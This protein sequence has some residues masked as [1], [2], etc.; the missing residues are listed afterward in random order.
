MHFDFPI[1]HNFFKI[2][3]LEWSQPLE[4]QIEVTYTLVYMLVA[5]T[6]LFVIS[7]DFLKVQIKLPLDASQTR[8]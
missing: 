8:R 4:F 7:T 1:F 5:L 3:K 6:C 2:Y